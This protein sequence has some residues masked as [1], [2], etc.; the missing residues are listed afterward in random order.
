MPEKTLFYKDLPANHVKV[1]K[2][3]LSMLFCTNMDGSEKLK[4][5][6]IGK[7][8]NPRCFKGINTANLPVYYRNNTKAWMTDEIF[9]EWLIKIDKQFKSENRKVILFLDNFSGHCDTS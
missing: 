8:K 4:P 5:I 2:E 6:L 9:R 7:S 1:E 3:R